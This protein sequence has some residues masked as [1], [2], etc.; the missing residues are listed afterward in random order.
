MAACDR[1]DQG[2]LT[3]LK[4]LQRIRTANGKPEIWWSPHHGW[5]VKNL[6]K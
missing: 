6:L 4:E 1:M 5:V 2:A 3:A